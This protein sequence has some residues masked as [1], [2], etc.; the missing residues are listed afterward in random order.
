MLE[1]EIGGLILNFAPF[2]SSLNNPLV[3]HL[4]KCKHIA[5]ARKLW[6]VT[7]ACVCS[8]VPGSFCNTEHVHLYLC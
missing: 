8:C 4:A 5:V 1:S 6:L 7:G 3:G 2:S